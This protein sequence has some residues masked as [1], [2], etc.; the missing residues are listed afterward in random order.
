MF[1]LLAAGA[2]GVVPISS[3]LSSVFSITSNT[4]NLIGEDEEEEKDGMNMESEVNGLM[5]GDEE[6]RELLLTNG[7]QTSLNTSYSD[8]SN[9]P[10]HLSFIYGDIGIDWMDQTYAHKF[11]K[12]IHNNILNGNVYFQDQSPYSNII[13]IPNA[14]HLVFLDEPE[15]TGLGIRKEVQSGRNMNM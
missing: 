14:G 8:E 2:W 15:R 5:V 12:Q 7:N 9:Q 1:Y 11:I 4:R 3:I 6:K 10:P 13:S